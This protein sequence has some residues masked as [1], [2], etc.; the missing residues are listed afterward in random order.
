MLEGFL[1]LREVI[2]ELRCS[3][4]RGERCGLIFGGEVD[5]LVHLDLYKMYCLCEGEGRLGI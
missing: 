5:I 4:K 2:I 1:R 3:K